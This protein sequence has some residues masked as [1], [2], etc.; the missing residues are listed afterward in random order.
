MKCAEFK[1][2]L[3][4]LLDGEMTQPEAKA[5]NE[6]I[7][8]CQDCERA[9]ARMATL[10]HRVRRLPEPAVHTALASKVKAE[11]FGEKRST[12]EILPFSVWRKVPVLM[13]ILVFALG[14]GNVVGKSM[15]SLLLDAKVDTRAEFLAQDTDHSL[16]D[17]VLDI[18]SE[19]NLR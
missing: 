13:L 3:S 5:L 8:L 15:T 11:L 9:Y 6:H 12:W 17:T 10:D 1:E 16:A 7:S 4:V 18:S 19:E 2:R 14:L